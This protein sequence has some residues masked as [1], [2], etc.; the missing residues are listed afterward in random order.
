M[1][2]LDSD[3]IVVGI[4]YRK[5][6][7]SKSCLCCKKSLEIVTHGFATLGPVSCPA[8]VHCI[9]PVL[10]CETANFQDC[11]GVNHPPYPP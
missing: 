6:R 9:L 8:E 5:D 4:C 7:K 3:F 2:F 10:P 1:K 11:G